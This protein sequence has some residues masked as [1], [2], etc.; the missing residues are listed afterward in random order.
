LT[1]KNLLSLFRGGQESYARDINATFTQNP[2]P[3]MFPDLSERNSLS[4]LHRITQV[5]ASQNSI[6]RHN[7]QAKEASP[8]T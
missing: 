6:S 8:L 5:N 4:H 2:N 1:A 7:G 3:V